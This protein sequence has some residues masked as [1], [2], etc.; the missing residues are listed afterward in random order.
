M[1]KIR[2]NYRNYV[3]KTMN[4]YG[5]HAGS[6]T[7]FMSGSQASIVDN[8]T[9][10]NMQSTDSLAKTQTQFKMNKKLDDSPS[11]FSIMKKASQSR[12]EIQKVQEERKQ[13]TT[14]LDRELSLERS[15][16]KPI[17]TVGNVLS[18]Q[19]S[20]EKLA[21]QPIVANSKVSPKGGKGAQPAPVPAAVIQHN[22]SFTSL[23]DTIA[24]MIVQVD[25]SDDCDDYK[26]ANEVL[27]G[28]K[29]TQFAMKYKL[30]TERFLQ[31]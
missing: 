9:Q 1:P 5:S 10:S 28:T 3:K 23:R 6:K 8:G 27:P 17:K 2:E 31:N 26:Q 4:D 30:D 29:K 19:G 16:Q 11:N 21:T 24:Q 7:L 13:R 22:D 15:P 12:F 20:D 25:E 18:P 14:L